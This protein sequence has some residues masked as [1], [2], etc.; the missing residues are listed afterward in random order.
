MLSEKDVLTL[1]VTGITNV[2]GEIL[3]ISYKLPLITEDITIPDDV[4]TAEISEFHLENNNVN[5]YS[6]SKLCVG[7]IY[8]MRELIRGND[9][10][11]LNELKDVFSNLDTKVIV[12]KNKGNKK[13]IYKILNENDI[14]VKNSEEFKKAIV[15]MSR[16]FSKVTEGISRIRKMHN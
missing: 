2:R 6:S 1:T 16:E 5:V 14:V 9:Y 12:Y 13:V 7:E 10:L 11:V 15:D 4:L 8:T 3:P